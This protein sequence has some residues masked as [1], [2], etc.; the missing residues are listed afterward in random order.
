MYRQFVETSDENQCVSL[1]EAFTDCYCERSEAISSSETMIPCLDDEMA[2]SQAPRNDSQNLTALLPG[3]ELTDSLSREK[4]I[5]GL[6]KLWIILRYFAPHFPPTGCD[7]ETMLW[8]WFSSV[9]AAQSLQDYC[10]LLEI[11]ATQLKDR[12]AWVSSTAESI[13]EDAENPMSHGY[14]RSKKPSA[15]ISW[16]EGTRYMRTLTD[17]LVYLTPFAMPD[18]TSLK[19]TLLSFRTRTG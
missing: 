14:L 15:G 4:R 17:N 5:F 16:L 3:G 13:P 7:P 9:E 8:D 19:E 10:H 18:V 11:V 1:P 6:C 2:S 12:H